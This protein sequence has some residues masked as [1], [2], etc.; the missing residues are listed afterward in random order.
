VVYCT[1]GYYGSEGLPGDIFGGQ[2][3]EFDYLFFHMKRGG[4]YIVDESVRAST[5]WNWGRVLGR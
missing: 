1:K 5:S 3:L 4:K 2:N